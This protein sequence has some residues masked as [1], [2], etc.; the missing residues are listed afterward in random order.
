MLTIR[1]IINFSLF[2]GNLVYQIEPTGVVAGFPQPISQV[3]AGLPNDLDAGFMYRNGRNYFFKV[4][5]LYAI[6]SGAIVSNI[7]SIMSIGV[8]FN[9]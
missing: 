8:A 9:Y 3:F 2:L 7:P 6:I 1:V 5:T 4:C